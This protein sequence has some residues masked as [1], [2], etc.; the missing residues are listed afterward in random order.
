MALSWKKL[1]EFHGSNFLICTKN[2]S[3]Y[4]K[5]V[6][7]NNN[8]SLANVQCTE[9]P[10][11]LHWLFSQY[12]LDI[13]QRRYVSARRQSAA[14]RQICRFIWMPWS[15]CPPLSLVLFTDTLEVTATDTLNILQSIIPKFTNGYFLKHSWEV[16]QTWSKFQ[17]GF[18]V[19]SG[20]NS[21]I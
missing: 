20:L 16:A 2:D 10:D 18:N 8:F 1:I 13:T 14:C 5:L 7:L 21:C 6:S 12:E 17:M 4:T 9:E 3:T 19:C 15:L 11:L